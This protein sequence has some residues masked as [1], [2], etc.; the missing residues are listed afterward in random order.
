[1]VSR[2]T[3]F[4]GNMPPGQRTRDVIRK[5]TSEYKVAFQVGTES[6]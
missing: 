3:T 5:E 2:V 6:L 4:L 1:M